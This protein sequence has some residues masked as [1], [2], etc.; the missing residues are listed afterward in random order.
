MVTEAGLEERVEVTESS[1]CQGAVPRSLE[2]LLVLALDRLLGN[3]P[4]RS[5]ASLER[6]YLAT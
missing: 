2:G 6:P 4:G 5:P 1:L 3:L